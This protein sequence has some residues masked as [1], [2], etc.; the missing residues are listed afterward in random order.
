MAAGS[1]GRGLSTDAR[2]REGGQVTVQGFQERGEVK[3]EQGG[4]LLVQHHQWTA[5]LRAARSGVGKDPAS[6]PLCMEGRSGPH[7]GPQVAGAKQEDRAQT[8]SSKLCVLMTM[9]NNEEL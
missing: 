1:P 7:G 8:L 4:I 9:D 5:Q 3:P 6:C 2:Q